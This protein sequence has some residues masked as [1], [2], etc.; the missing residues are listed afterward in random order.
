MV[1]KPKPAYVKSLPGLSQ[2][3]SFRYY[4][5]VMG[6]AGKWLGLCYWLCDLDT[7]LAWDF[8]TLS[9]VTSGVDL[10]ISR[11]VYSPEI[12]DQHPRTCFW[13]LLTFGVYASYF[14]QERTSLLSPSGSLSIKKRNSNLD[15][16]NDLC[17]VED[18]I[19]A[20]AKPCY[21]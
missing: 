13:C 6:N 3:V 15:V 8:T 7:S 2:A 12:L 20:G 17:C 21:C 1:C 5:R 16:Q 14:V 18:S 19:W 11:T 9:S 4:G 10:I